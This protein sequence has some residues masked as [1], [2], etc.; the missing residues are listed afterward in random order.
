MKAD[1]HQWL[2]LIDRA[3][4]VDHK[5]I[6]DPQPPSSKSI[7]RLP[8][9]T[10]LCNQKAMPAKDI[11]HDHVRIALERDGWTITHDPYYMTIGHKSLPIDLGAERMLAAEKGSEKIAIEV[12]SFRGGS[13]IHDFHSALGQYLNYRLGLQDSETSRDLYLAIPNSV[14]ES[15]NEVIL[16]QRSV[17]YYDLKLIIFQP[18]EKRILSWRK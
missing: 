9:S 5:V 14:Y 13:Q 16:F 11:F 2:R 10:Y 17:E 18:T 15:L 12:K 7:F 6:A 1:G 8:T 3:I 4:L